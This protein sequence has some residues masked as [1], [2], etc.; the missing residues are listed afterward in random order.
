MRKVLIIKVD[1]SNMSDDEIWDL[2]DAMNVQ[3][4]GTPAD[5][6]EYSSLLTDTFDP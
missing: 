6:A 3:R 5:D 1:V 2:E 4:E